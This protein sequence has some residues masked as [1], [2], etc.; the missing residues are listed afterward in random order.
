MPGIN[1]NAAPRTHTGDDEMFGTDEEFLDFDQQ[2]EQGNSWLTNGTLGRVNEDSDSE[3]DTDEPSSMEMTHSSLASPASIIS[4]TG[5]RLGS[6]L[7]VSGCVT[8]YIG[9]FIRLSAR[10]LVLL[11]TR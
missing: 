1:K 10:R 4:H 6:A 9:D 11:N 7:P 8:S 3:L 2:R 5:G